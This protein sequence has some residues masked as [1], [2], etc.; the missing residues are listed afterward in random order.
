M[1]G[2]AQSLRAGGQTVRYLITPGGFRTIRTSDRFSTPAGWKSEA[3]GELPLRAYAEDALD[4][5][6][7]PALVAAVADV[8]S[9]LTLGIDVHG[10]N[11]IHAEFVATV[12]LAA[13][14]ARRTP[15]ATWTGKSY[16]ADGQENTLVHIVDV[17]SHCQVI[18]G[19][20]VLVL[21]CHDLSVY[22]PRGAANL[23]AGSY[24]SRRALEVREEVRGFE[25]T[26]VLHH[27]HGTDTARTWALSWSALRTAL[28]SART[29]ASAIRHKNP[30]ASSERQP[31]DQVLR[32]TRSADDATIDVVVSATS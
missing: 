26:V 6:L 4:E 21:G 29:F 19:D 27:P 13:S 24:R 18:G 12:D 15:V 22:N 20:R 30:W 8:A 31:L 16:P 28:P 7:A 2:A 1:E 23:S 32:D 17:A 11:G 3:G 14:A 5:L 9:F 10:S 25:P